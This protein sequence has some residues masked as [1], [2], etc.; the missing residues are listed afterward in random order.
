MQ[1]N[2]DFSDCVINGFIMS[3]TMAMTRHN[4]MMSRQFQ[5]RSVG[6]SAENPTSENSPEQSIG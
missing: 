3:G 6:T 5:P 1:H 2:A 4:H